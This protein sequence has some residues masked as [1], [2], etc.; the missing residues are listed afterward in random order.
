MSL[1]LSKTHNDA[2]VEYIYNKLEDEQ[3]YYPI[4][5]L[6]LEKRIRYLCEDIYEAAY[7]D[8]QETEK[9]EEEE[10]K[11][12]NKINVYGN[13]NDIKQMKKIVNDKYN[14]IDISKLD[15]KKIHINNNDIILGD[16]L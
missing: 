4:L 8:G 9:L 15:L 16:T 5:D 14:Y 6:E 12:K 10:N 2:I 11:T 13:T 7:K 3:L 1:N